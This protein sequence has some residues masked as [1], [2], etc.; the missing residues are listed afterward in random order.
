MIQFT[1][2]TQTESFVPIKITLG[3]QT[4]S[5][6]KGAQIGSIRRI[7]DIFETEISL[8][9]LPYLVSIRF[10]AS[11]EKRYS[12]KILSSDLLPHEKEQKNSLD[13]VGERRASWPGGRLAL[14]FLNPILKLEV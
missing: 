8:K 9:N 10:Q 6:H 12:L 13:T 5:F 11:I 3:A 2:G 4:D 7:Q 14:F 1:L